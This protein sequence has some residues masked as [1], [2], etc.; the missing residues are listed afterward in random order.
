MQS[1]CSRAVPGDSLL[2]RSNEI[3][4]RWITYSISQLRCGPLPKRTQVPYAKQEWKVKT[5]AETFCPHT[6]QKQKHFSCELTSLNQNLCGWTFA[7]CKIYCIDLHLTYCF[8]NKSDLL[9]LNKASYLL[10][11]LHLI[12]KVGIMAPFESAQACKWRFNVPCPQDNLNPQD[13]PVRNRPSYLIYLYLLH[14]KFLVTEQHPAKTA[15]P[16][17]EPFPLTWSRI[18]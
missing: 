14:Q 18:L 9:H 4:S 13:N 6:L 5:T 1:K 8:E 3:P 7:R 17:G 10:H 2:T 12:Y 11:W 15:W 16:R